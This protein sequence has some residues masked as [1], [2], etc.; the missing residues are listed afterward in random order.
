MKST[1]L[2]FL[3]LVEWLTV[4][5]LLANWPLNFTSHYEDI[6]KFSWRGVMDW[7]FLQINVYIYGLIFIYFI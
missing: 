1:V 4:Q 7:I 3:S 6:A 5:L 2:L